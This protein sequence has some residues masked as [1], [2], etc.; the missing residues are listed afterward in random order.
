MEKFKEV[1]IT[2]ALSIFVGLVL[3]FFKDAVFF[4]PF[5]QI[6]VINVLVLM[7]IVF[8][9]MDIRLIT[10]VVI[11]DMMLARIVFLVFE[12]LFYAE[13]GLIFIWPKIAE[14]IGSLADTRIIK[15]SLK[16]GLPSDIVIVL[17]KYALAVFIFA[18]VLDSSDFFKK[19]KNRIKVMY[20]RYKQKKAT[21]TYRHQQYCY[22]PALSKIQMQLREMDELCEPRSRRKTHS[23]STKDSY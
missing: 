23:S 9:L 8:V 18:C 22:C 20:F 14:L 6:N 1:V 4:K 11:E 3:S 15:I 19:W 17:L 10:E 7:S 21:E 12:C 13:L 16:F 5:P 2:K